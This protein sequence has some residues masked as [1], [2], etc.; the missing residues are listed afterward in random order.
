LNA[1]YPRAPA[2]ELK[3]APTFATAVAKRGLGY[4]RLDQLTI[5]HIMGARGL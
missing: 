2:Q 3:A 4:E 5:E 1:S